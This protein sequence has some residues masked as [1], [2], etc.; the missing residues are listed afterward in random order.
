MK[1]Q[2]ED[3]VI[4]EFKRRLAQYTELPDD[5]CWNFIE[6][7]LPKSTGSFR[8][9]WLISL[10]FLL[11]QSS[12]IAF[13]RNKLLYPVNQTSAGSMPRMV[14]DFCLISPVHQSGTS[15]KTIAGQNQSENRFPP[16]KTQIHSL[17]INRGTLTDTTS[18]FQEEIV[19]LSIQEDLR[20]N[21]IEQADSVQEGETAEPPLLADTLNAIEQSVLVKQKKNKVKFLSSIHSFAFLP[22]N[23]S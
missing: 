16:S 11:C 13:L 14:N 6:G 3:R 20:E 12:E 8:W 4:T 1:S 10:L 22:Q 7:Q 21:F 5:D 19:R 18:T 15:L 9:T 23:Y 17:F 2:R